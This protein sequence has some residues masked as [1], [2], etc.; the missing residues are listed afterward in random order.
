MYQYIPMENWNRDQGI[1]KLISNDDNYVINTY[2]VATTAW[3][4]P[5]TVTRPIQ[6]I[7][8]T[9]IIILF[10]ANIH[11]IHATILSSHDIVCINKI[12]NNFCFLPEY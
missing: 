1:Q 11:T 4:P 10:S 3:L 5:T 2:K 7:T 8:N 9:G 12:L 6:L